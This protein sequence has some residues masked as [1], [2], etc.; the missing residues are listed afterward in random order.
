MGRARLEGIDA[1]QLFCEGAIPLEL[2]VSLQEDTMTDFELEVSAIKLTDEQWLEVKD[3]QRIYEDE[4]ADAAAAHA[5]WRLARRARAAAAA[6][7]FA[8][9]VSHLVPSVPSA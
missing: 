4:A 6:A 5:A 3:L 7:A 2:T 9:A 8:A 1:D